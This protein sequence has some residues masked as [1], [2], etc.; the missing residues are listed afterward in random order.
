VLAFYADESGS[1][2]LHFPNQPWVVFAAVGFDDDHWLTIDEDLNEL[3]RAYFPWF[4]PH[5]VEI[6]SND[7]RMAAIRPHS[8]N[9][10]SRLEPAA[11]RRF[12]HE[13]YEVIETLPFSWCAVA[14]YKPS[15]VHDLRVT[16]ERQLFA[17]AYRSLIRLL[18]AWCENEASVGRLFVDQRESRSHGKA[19]REI[20]DLHA[21]RRQHARR[22][23]V[24]E[25]PYFQDSAR[26]NH[27]QLAD[28]IA[29]NVLRRY[30]DDDVE[31]PY[32]ARLVPK[33]YCPNGVIGAG[34]RLYDPRNDDSG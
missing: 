1:F 13:L 25:R 31:Y 33:L 27:I 15:I 18:D 23:H 29:Y 10:F 26:S 22:F 28:V 21:C 34:L 5:D 14:M 20:A 17:L 7:I 19:H 8:G 12:G 3:K 4:P 24:V 2:D 11:L 9:P 32:F 30:R 6:R 16:N